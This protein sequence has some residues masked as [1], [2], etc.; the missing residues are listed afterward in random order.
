MHL[1]AVHQYEIR[2]SN[3]LTFSQ[4]GKDIISPF[5]QLATSVEVA[6]ENTFREKIT[7]SFDENY[8]III[9]WDRII[10]RKEG[11]IDNLSRRNSVIEEP[12]YSILSKLKTLS[13]FGQIRNMLYFSYWVRPNEDLNKE[14]IVDRFKTRYL[15]T[16]SIDIQPEMTD[17]AIHIESF[18]ELKQTFITI[19]PY[20]GINDLVKQQID[21]NDEKLKKD[22]ECIGDAIIFKYFELAKVASFSE[23][24]DIAKLEQEYINKIWEN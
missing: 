4:F 23:Y 19:G 11:I 8:Q 24:K 18:G 9:S 2:Y 3:I 12:F 22:L 21:I 16:N 1:T 17:L 13:G 10:L 14:E 6:H 5:V 20:L 15:S 7:L